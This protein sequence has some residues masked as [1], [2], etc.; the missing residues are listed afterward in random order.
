MAQLYM[1]AHHIIQ[2]VLTD[3]VLTGVFDRFPGL[4]LVSVENDVSWLPHF[5]TRLDHY[6]ERFVTLIPNKL[7]MTP[8]D[9]IKRHFF[10]TFTF[11]GEGIES[12]RRTLGSEGMMWGNDYPHLDS[13]WP[14]STELI[15]RSLRDLLPAEDVG[16]LLHHNVVKLYGLDPAELRSAAPASS[17]G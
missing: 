10:S 12:V 9:Y 3:I 11:E 7:R 4:R 15:Q 14:K 6:A 5:A 17:Q 8:T 1:G 16:N 2:R 13:S